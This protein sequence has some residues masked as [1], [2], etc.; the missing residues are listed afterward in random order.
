MSVKRSHVSEILKLQLGDIHH[1]LFLTLPPLELTH[2]LSAPCRFFLSASRWKID[3]TSDFI[4]CNFR[5]V[6]MCCEL[7]T[8][9]WRPVSLLSVE[10]EK[11]VSWFHGCSRRWLS[12]LI[13]ETST[14]LPVRLSH[15]LFIGRLPCHTQCFV[16]RGSLYLTI[17]FFA[18]FNWFLYFIIIWI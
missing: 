15:L 11:S 14:L 13:P 1:R 6:L 5:T 18:N 4:N 9:N 7:V 16:K 2:C 12:S 8:S 3:Q 17:I 10:L